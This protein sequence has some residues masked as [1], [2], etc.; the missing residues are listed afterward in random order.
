MSLVKQ[1]SKVL[2]LSKFNLTFYEIDKEKKKSFYYLITFKMKSQ[3]VK[4]N[5]LEKKCFS[6]IAY[7]YRIVNK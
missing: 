2:S 6:R 7:L 4:V 3:K 5:S 1:F